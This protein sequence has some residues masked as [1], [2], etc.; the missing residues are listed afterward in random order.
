[1]ENDQVIEI[2]KKIWY[3][4]MEQKMTLVCLC[5]GTNEIIGMN[6]NFVRTKENT[7]CD[8]IIAE[9]NYCFFKSL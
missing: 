4:L 8:N 5:E 6:I 1:M 3:G 9:V 2:F 7:Y